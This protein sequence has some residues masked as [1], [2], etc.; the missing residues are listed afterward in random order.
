MERASEIM[1][2]LPGA[3]KLFTCDQCAA[4]LRDALE[5]EGISGTTLR[6]QARNADGSRSL[7]NVWS[8]QAG[9][10]ISQNGFHEAIQLGDTVFDNMNPQGIAREA[11]EADLHTPLGVALDIAEEAF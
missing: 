6:V 5:A 3:G 9:A 11:W 1:S 4:G 8:D 7:A 10:N 2:S